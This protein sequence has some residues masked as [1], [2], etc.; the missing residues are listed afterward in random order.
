MKKFRSLLASLVVFGLVFLLWGF[1]ALS[2]TQ[3]FCLAG[4]FQGALLCLDRQRP[5][6]FMATF[7]Q[8]QVDEFDGLC[9]D[10]EKI[11]DRV[12]RLETENDELRG[13]IKQLKKIGLAG[14][15]GLRMFAVKYFLPADA[16][17]EL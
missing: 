14:R 9:K 15:N 16:A 3:A 7:S 17:I 12:K 11:P 10:L 2:V 6:L 8:A 1:G 5:A 4:L 13:L